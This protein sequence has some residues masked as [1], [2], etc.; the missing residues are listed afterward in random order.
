MKIAKVKCKN[1]K[2]EFEV[3][4]N[5]PK[6]LLVCPGCES[7]EMDFEIT[8]EEFTGCGGSCSG[9]SSCE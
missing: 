8:E 1:C 9:C 2:A 3:L 5:F 4:E 6:D 7:K